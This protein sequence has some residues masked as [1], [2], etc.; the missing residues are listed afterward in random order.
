V[1]NW[2]EVLLNYNMAVGIRSQWWQSQGVNK[3]AGSSE[4]DYLA[5]FPQM[6]CSLHKRMYNKKYPKSARA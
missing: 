2:T 3:W 6:G 1:K 5:R 4:I